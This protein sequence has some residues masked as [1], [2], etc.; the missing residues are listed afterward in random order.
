MI[1]STIKLFH[2][3]LTARDHVMERVRFQEIKVEK[4]KEKESKKKRL[5]SDRMK[6]KKKPK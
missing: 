6:K 2:N 5:A 3:L 1:C 4:A